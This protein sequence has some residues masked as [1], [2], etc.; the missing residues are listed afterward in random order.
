MKRFALLLL[1]VAA[2]G[3]GFG[4]TAPDPRYK[5][6]VALRAWQDGEREFAAG[7]HAEAVRR[8]SNA[9]SLSVEPFPQAHLG[10]ARSLEALGEHAAARAGFTAALDLAPEDKKSIYLFHRGRHAQRRLEH[11]QA[12]AD[13]TRAAELEV[14]WPEPEYALAIQIHRGLALIDLGRAD[15]A[16]RVL[17]A[18]LERKPDPEMRRQVEELKAKARDG[19]LKR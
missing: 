6:E 18:I 1:P 11:P 5:E 14:E 19:G 3:C 15:E 9:I 13:F 10:R 12:L 8:Y 2:A 16:V 4:R 7:N 17:D